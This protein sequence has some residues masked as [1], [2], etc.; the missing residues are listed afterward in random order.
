MCMKRLRHQKIKWKILSKVR[1]TNHVQ[2]LLGV[3]NSL[4]INWNIYRDTKRVMRT[5][6][7]Q[8]A[9]PIKRKRKIGKVVRIT[10]ICTTFKSKI[11]T[12]KRSLKLNL[13]DNGS[14]TTTVV[15]V[16][17]TYDLLSI[18]SNHKLYVG[19]NPLLNHKL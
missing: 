2:I 14:I 11:T 3:T 7:L 10:V 13:P 19:C 18:W 17:I 5:N 12:K 1:R 6:K 4:L 8:M 9:T 16:D 15:V